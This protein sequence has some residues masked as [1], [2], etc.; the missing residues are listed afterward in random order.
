VP[1][2][3]N[4]DGSLVANLIGAASYRTNVDRIL[5]AHDIPLEGPP[6]MDRLEREVATIAK[7]LALQA[8]HRSSIGDG[9]LQGDDRLVAMII[10]LIATDYLSA[11]AETKFEPAGLLACYS[12]SHELC[13]EIEEERFGE[14]TATFNS[15]STQRAKVLAA[16]GNQIALFYTKQA[17]ESLKR[18]GELFDIMRKHLRPN[19]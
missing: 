15:L 13:G 10:A 8:I 9:R 17:D 6:D 1:P 5:T 19:S 7:W 4:E 12:L 3:S 11:R 14:A 18:L 2:S 16:V